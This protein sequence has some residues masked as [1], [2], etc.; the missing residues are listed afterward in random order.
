MSIVAS[1]PQ[2]FA[3]ARGANYRTLVPFKGLSF[4]TMLSG[5]T[6]YRT[7][8]DPNA[9]P[10]WST[11][12]LTGPANFSI[13]SSTQTL[14]SSLVF[15]SGANIANSDGLLLYPFVNIPYT[16]SGAP[17]ICIGDWLFMAKAGTGPDNQGFFKLSDKE[18]ELVLKAGAYGRSA[19]YSQVNGAAHTNM[20]NQQGSFSV[21]NPQN[22]VFEWEGSIDSIHPLNSGNTFRFSVGAGRIH[23][24]NTDPEQAVSYNPISGGSLLSLSGNGVWFIA[25][26]NANKELFGIFFYWVLT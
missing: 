16:V 8:S 19:L 9:I 18:I 25:F 3:L 5:F 12:N 22:Y 11:S 10:G 20:T 4:N 2:L 24:A 7:L 23:R 1:F 13:A 17:A 15:K 14:G 26:P 21:N 6:P